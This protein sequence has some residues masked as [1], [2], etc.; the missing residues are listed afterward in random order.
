MIT[1][2]QNKEKLDQIW[3]GFLPK[4]PSVWL[5]PQTLTWLLSFVARVYFLPITRKGR[6]AFFEGKTQRLQW[7]LL[8][9]PKVSHKYVSVQ[10]YIYTI[11]I[12]ITHLRLKPSKEHEQQR[13][14]CPYAEHWRKQSC[15]Q[16]SSE[17]VSKL[18]AILE[19]VSFMA[20]SFMHLLYPTSLPH[21]CYFCLCLPLLSQIF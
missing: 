2:L 5:K 16:S 7:V 21:C 8:S 1:L 14:M 11:E 4:K 12:R 3:S 19:L 13:K 20:L 6:N 17:L 15:Q 9:S 18:A 10:V